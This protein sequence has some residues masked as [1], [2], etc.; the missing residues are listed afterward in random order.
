[1]GQMPRKGTFNGKIGQNERLD[2]SWIRKET[3]GSYLETVGIDGRNVQ[4]DGE[5]SM[6]SAGG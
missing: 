5:I 3:A 2:G 4:L 6:K 1:M